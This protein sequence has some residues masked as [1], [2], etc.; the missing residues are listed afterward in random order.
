MLADAYYMEQQKAKKAGY[1]W[2]QA[3]Q[4]A[5]FLRNLGAAGDGMS[6][7]DKVRQVVTQIG[8]ILGYVRMVRT[9]GMRCVGRSLPYVEAGALQEANPNENNKKP[10]RLADPNLPDD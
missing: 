9:A 8:N 3:M 4:T 6:F 2:G 10:Q 7:L 5:R 1:T